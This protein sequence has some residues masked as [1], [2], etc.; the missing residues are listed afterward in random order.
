MK[1]F[2][3]NRIILSLFL[4][5]FTWLSSFYFSDGICKCIYLHGIILKFICITEMLLLEPTLHK[6]SL[7]Y[8]KFVQNVWGFLENSDVE[9]CSSLAHSVFQMGLIFCTSLKEGG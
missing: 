4:L 7:E 6:Q 1:N 2:Q 8:S 3:E 5:I 9:K